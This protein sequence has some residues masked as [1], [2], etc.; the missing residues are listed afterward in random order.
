[1]MK[2]NKEGAATTFDKSSR[3][4]L[5][6]L[7]SNNDESVKHLL[8]QRLLHDNKTT[9]GH[10][11]FS[12]PPAINDD[13]RNLPKDYLE[14]KIIQSNLLRS[15][16]NNNDDVKSTAKLVDT[17]G[18]MPTQ[19]DHVTVLQAPPT[20]QIGKVSFIKRRNVVQTSETTDGVGA[21]LINNAATP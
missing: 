11:I 9:G 7:G 5:D 15:H 12:P 19:S 1:M 14:D 2:L 16:H 13:S 4:V 18:A 17:I 3:T 8:A 10:V 20:T 21:V 6:D